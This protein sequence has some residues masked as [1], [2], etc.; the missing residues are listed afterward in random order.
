[1]PG[2]GE[3]Q[4]QVGDKGWAQ[5]GGAGSA[6]LGPLHLRVFV[7]GGGWGWGCS[8]RK[9]AGLVPSALKSLPGFC[10]AR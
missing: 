4:F 10:R 2:K 9:K 6:V 1:M 8:Q 3:D 7:C 5:V